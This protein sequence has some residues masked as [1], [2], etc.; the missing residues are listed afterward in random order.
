MPDGGEAP[1]VPYIQS[2]V[3]PGRPG[4]GG[5]EDGGLGGRMGLWGGGDGQD[6]YGD[7][8]II[9]WEDTAS[10]VMLGTDPNALLAYDPVL[11]LH[12]PIMSM[13]G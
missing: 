12:H 8:R 5:D 4:L 7:R 2:V 6:R 1:G 3:G 11:E 13:I 9:S 10:N